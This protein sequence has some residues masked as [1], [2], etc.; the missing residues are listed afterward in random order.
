MAT[1]KRLIDA[2]KLFSAIRDDAEI[3]GTTYA[4]VKE[5]IFNAEDEVV[6]GRWIKA[7]CSEKDGDS[8]CSNCGQWDWHDCKYCHNCGA[9]MD[10]EV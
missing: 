3:R 2:D 1:E 8:N 4:R 10:L 9:K 6:H 5:H 7:E